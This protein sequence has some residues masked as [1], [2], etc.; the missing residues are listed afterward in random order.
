MGYRV[1]YSDEIEHGW[2][3]KDHKYI[4]REVGAN[5][6]WIYTYTSDKKQATKLTKTDLWRARSQR[7]S[8]RKDYDFN[9]NLL[10]KGTHNQYLVNKER[11]EL[12]REKINKLTKE[13]EEGKRLETEMKSNSHFKDSKSYKKVS[14]TLAKLK[15]ELEGTSELSRTYTGKA[16]AGKRATSNTKFQYELAT[17]K[18]DDIVAQY[19]KQQK[20]LVNRIKKLLKIK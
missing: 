13:I 10:N 11:G 18:Y 12:N 17:K 7:D 4:K 5:G 2:F 16:I 9:S 20:S 6:Q 19:E 14:E 15:S 1:V 8:T 3:K